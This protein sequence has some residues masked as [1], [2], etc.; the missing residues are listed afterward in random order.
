MKV[1]W[2]EIA[3]WTR[4]W[5]SS[6]SGLPHSVG[7]LICGRYNHELWPIDREKGEVTVNGHLYYLQNARIEDEKICGYRAF[8]L[9]D[10]D[11]NNLM[12]LWVVGFYEQ[13]INELSEKK[14]KIP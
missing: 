2:A 8:G 12:K 7:P 13:K 4:F 9:T 11:Y 3:S 6:E 10:V 1:E 5:A 14:V